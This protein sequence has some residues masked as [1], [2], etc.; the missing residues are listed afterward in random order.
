MGVFLILVAK[1]PASVWEV[2]RSASGAIANLTNKTSYINHY[3]FH[4]M[5]PQWG[6]V[7]IKMSGHPPFGA[8]VI[9]NG[10]STLLARPAGGCT[11]PHRAHRRWVRKRPLGRWRGPAPRPLVNVKEKSRRSDREKPR[12]SDREKPAFLEGAP[13]DRAGDAGMIGRTSGVT[14]GLRPRPPASGS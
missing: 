7:T 3:S 13:R 2:S 6:H 1:A 4:V 8:Q 10:T 9:L 11:R 5:D 14:S 12:K